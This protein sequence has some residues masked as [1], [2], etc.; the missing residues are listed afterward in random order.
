MTFTVCLENNQSRRY[1]PSFQ[2]SK[3]TYYIQ[4]TV[5]KHTKY[6]EEEEVD[7]NS[8]IVLVKN[9]LFAIEIMLKNDD[10]DTFLSSIVYLVALLFL[11]ADEKYKKS[12]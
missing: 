10:R 3:T 9:K 7:D 4:V 6:G 8:C 5:D 11:S 2:I 1:R 12:K